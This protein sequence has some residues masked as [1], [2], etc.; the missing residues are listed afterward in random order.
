MARS[1]L[2]LGSEER[3]YLLAGELV[4]QGEQSLRELGG[5]DHA[6]VLGVEALESADELLF[7]GC[8]EVRS[9]LYLC[10]LPPHHRHELSEAKGVPTAG[11]NFLE[12]LLEVLG[13]DLD[14]LNS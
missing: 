11:S 6:S 10:H 13:G 7:G 1:S 14:A 2:S 5:G 12:H 9:L 3:R 8:L 4:A